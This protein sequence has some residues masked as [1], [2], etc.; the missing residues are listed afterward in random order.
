LEEVTRLKKFYCIDAWRH[1]DNYTDVANIS[2]QTHEQY[3][4]EACRQLNPWKTSVIFIRELSTDG[5]NQIPDCSLDF[6]YIDANHS[7]D[8]VT[9][10]L[11]AYLP[12]MKSNSIMAGHDYLDG[13]LSYGVFGVA[14]AVDSF[15]KDV[16]YRQF[17]VTKEEFPSWILIL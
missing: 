8:Y 15:K 4:Q 9:Q 13:I 16:G 14:S 17:F 5:A 10:D 1:L 3:Y 12:K 11:Y 2:D 6:V 7:M